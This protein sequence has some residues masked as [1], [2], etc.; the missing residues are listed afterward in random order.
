M[1]ANHAQFYPGETSSPDEI[2]RLADEYRNAVPTLLELRRK[3]ST[4]S[5]GP[6]RLV[7]IHAI[8]LYLNAFLI[9]YGERP[10]TVRGY[11]HQLS[12]LSAS[13]CEKGLILK[14]T[15]LGHLEAM[16]GD[17]E[18]LCARYNPEA[19]GKSQLNRITSTLNEVAQKV[20]KKVQ[21]SKAA[22]AV[23]P[24]P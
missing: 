9:A 1:L 23:A 8:E 7:A 5:T 21:A 6:F 16:A 14:R 11:H 22:S 18:Y 4:V 15:T 2:I 3:G 17:R 10:A 13:A 12:K 20:S 24:T 19:P